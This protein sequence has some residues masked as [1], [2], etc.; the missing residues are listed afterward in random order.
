MVEHI[1]ATRHIIYL[2]LE[3]EQRMG[4]RVERRWQDPERIDLADV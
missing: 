4:A 3:A 1:N 2:C